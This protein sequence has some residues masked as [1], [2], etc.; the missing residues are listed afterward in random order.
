MSAVIPEANVRIPAHQSPS[1]SDGCHL[2]CGFSPSHS[3]FY[4]TRLCSPQHLSKHR[5]MGNTNHQI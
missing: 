2:T 5:K 1:Q 4:Y 3:E